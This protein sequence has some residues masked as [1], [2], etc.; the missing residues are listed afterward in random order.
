MGERD[1]KVGRSEL[2]ASDPLGLWSG[3]PWEPWFSLSPQPSSLL[4]PVTPKQLVSLEWL[5]L[6]SSPLEE[7]GR[8]WVFSW[9]L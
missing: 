1:M 6:L 9:A 7:M 4:S 3:Y 8:A 5:F 2:I